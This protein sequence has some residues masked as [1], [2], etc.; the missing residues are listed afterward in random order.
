MADRKK[1]K[2]QRVEEPLEVGLDRYRR[3]R[4]RLP[5][6]VIE[7]AALIVLGSFFVFVVLPFVIF[8]G[9]FGSAPTSAQDVTRLVVRGAPS[10]VWTEGSSTELQSVKV[11]VG[12]IG[13]NLARDVRVTVSKGGKVFVLTGATQIESGKSEA[14]SGNVTGIVK[15][16]ADL[17][18]SVT[19]VNC[20]HE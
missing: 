5:A 9:R 13:G 8:G 11:V 19:C 15:A 17:Q 1:E 20:I 7:R 2:I 4:N 10:K 14:F 6:W 18:V 16:D 3:P 12:N